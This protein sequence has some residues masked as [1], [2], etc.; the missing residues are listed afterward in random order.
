MRHSKV[1]AAAGSAVLLATFTAT[2]APATTLASVLPLAA[3]A[4]EAAFTD[5]SA[6]ADPVACR[7]PEPDNRVST[8][9]HST[10]RTRSARSTACVH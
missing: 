7:R 1:A 5:A 9:I 4:P 2:A 3:Q 8:T 10:R 6:A